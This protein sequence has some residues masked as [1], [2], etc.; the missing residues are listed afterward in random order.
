MKLRVARWAWLGLVLGVACGG[1]SDEPVVDAGI[2]PVQT[3][4]TT[5]GTLPGSAPVAPGAG[6][7]GAGGGTIGAMGGTQQTM[8]PLPT[9]PTV[10]GTLAG[11][12]GLIAGRTGGTGATAGGAGGGDAGVA[13]AP[14]TPLGPNCLKGTGDFNAN[15]PYKI[16]KTD[17]MIGSQGPYTIFAPDPLEAS[18]PHP[19]V[20]WGNGTGVSDSSTYGFYQEHAASWG[21]VVVAA[22]NSNVGSGAWHKAGLDYLLQQN[23][24]QGSPYFGKLSTRAGTSGHSQGGGGA[25]AGASHPN[26]TT[27]VNVQGAFGSAPRGKNF[28]CLTGT[29]DISPEGCKSSVDGATSPAFLANWEGGD[30][31]GTATLLGYITG[32]KGTKQ[33]MRLYSAWFRCHLA[34]DTQACAMFMGGM[35][36]PLCKEPGWNTIYAKNF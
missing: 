8:P 11:A 4:G 20:A 22:H 9:N 6:A 1:E 35:S 7:P 10:G 23:T 13:A 36:C 24:T 18:C 26:V 12:G 32:D 31:T 15:G 21:I 2:A 28:L 17:L 5:A 14:L 34:N 30:H 16:K 29:M 19:I 3:G 33:Y 27:I 25:N